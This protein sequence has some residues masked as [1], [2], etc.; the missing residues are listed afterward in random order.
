MI[1]ARINASL[2]ITFLIVFDLPS[3]LKIFRR[4]PVDSPDNYACIL[5]DKA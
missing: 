3:T 4:Y 2:L 1:E 5:G